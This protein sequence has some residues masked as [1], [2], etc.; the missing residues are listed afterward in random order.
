M[1][2][3]PRC[4]CSDWRF[5]ALTWC[6]TQ[7]A[8]FVCMVSIDRYQLR[9]DANLVDSLTRNYQGKRKKG[10]AAFKVNN[11]KIIRSDSEANRSSIQCSSPKGFG[12]RIIIL[13]CLHWRAHAAPQMSL[14]RL[15]IPFRFF[16]SSKW[17]ASGSMF[18]R[19]HRFLSLYLSL[20]SCGSSCI[21]ITF[22]GGN[23][24][25]APKYQVCVF[26]Q[27]FKKVIALAMGNV[28]SCVAPSSHT[29]G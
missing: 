23:L 9:H 14:Q 16:G 19:V 20:S 7:H 11:N 24:H 21:F 15:K 13:T 28:I 6:R 10:N 2:G 8:F 3:R 12:V 25:T 27:Q 22:I 17:F 5:I 29:H 26:T 18:R 4:C 1:N